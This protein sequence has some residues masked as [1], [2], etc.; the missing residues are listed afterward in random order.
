M[1][2]AIIS[3]KGGTGKSSISAAF[4]TLE[5]RV[6]LADCDVDAANLYILFNPSHEEEEVYIAGQK[7]VIDDSLCI[8]CGLCKEYC[9]FDAIFSSEGKIVIHEISCDG[10]RLCSRICPQNA[11]K[12]VDNNKSRMYAGSFRNGKMVYGRLA[13]GEENSGKLVNIV[14]EKARKI[15]LDHN[16]ENIIIDGPPGIGCAVISSITGTNNVVIVTEPTISG[17]I[18]LKRTI[19][20]TSKFQLKVW[21]IINKYDLNP[22][23]SNK[24]EKYCTE[25]DINFAGKLRFNPQVVESMVKCKSI[26]EYAPDSQI[27]EQIRKIWHKINSNKKN[28]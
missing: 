8:N 18:D 6:V 21:V 28:G 13:P 3:G 19:E 11:I 27:S 14:R 26:I 12:M 20:I 16:I 5:G 2:T 23:L 1:E 22:D 17:L 10:C 9:R 24:I 7:A 4:A 25:C 15:S